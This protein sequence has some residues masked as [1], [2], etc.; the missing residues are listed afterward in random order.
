V[1]TYSEAVAY[2]DG[3]IGRGMH[4]GLETVAGLLELMGNPQDSYPVVHIAGTN[5]KTSVARMVT[6][7]CIAH[8]L[9]TGT[10][11][12]PHLEAVEERVSVN[13]MPTE[14]EDF[15]QAVL[16]VKAFAD[17]YEERT[18]RQISYFELTAALAFSW[19][20]DQA[21]DVG[22]IEVGLGGRLDATNAAHA[23]VA[24]LT[25][26]GMDH[27]EY[28]GDTIEAIAREKLAIVEEGSILVTGPLPESVITI[29][30]EV[31]RERSAELRLY[32]RDFRLEGSMKGVGG[33][34]IDVEGTQG[35]YEEIFLPVHGRFQ[36]INFAVA[37]A[38][39]EAL[40]NRALDGDAVIDAA[41]VLTNPGRME[42]MET[43]PPL[44]LDGAHNADGFAALAQSLA[45][46]Y[47]TTRWVVV[48]AAM[49]DK[50]LTGMWAPIA[51]RLLGVVA[52]QVDSPRARSAADLGAR[53]EALVGDT[54]V[55]VVADPVEAVAHARTLAGEGDGLL[56]TGSLYLV[57]VIRAHLT[58][59]HRTPNER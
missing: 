43:D 46:E 6:V 31:C 35:V 2:L 8:G 34:Q 54:P 51:P 36:T 58:G 9:T 15:V 52:T 33:W 38:A 12:S 39:V 17:I 18:G 27:S 21:V 40:T 53:L 57:G 59:G 20:A 37:I 49:E 14:A 19:F 4:P 44:I 25:S 10:F 30:E 26:V 29:A 48:T 3:H 56:V 22:V 24:V 5:G 28:L 32:G 13:G 50:D 42:L 1:L 45:E 47:P 16:D 41:A 11:T 7:L 23:T 55:T